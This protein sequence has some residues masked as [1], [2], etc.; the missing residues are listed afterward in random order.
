[1][2][3]K[4][5]FYLPNPPRD[6]RTFNTDSG[7]ANFRINKLENLSS[8][9]NEFVMMTI[10]SHDQYNTTI[11]SSN[12]RYRG[13]KGGRRIIFMNPEDILSS[14]ISPDSKVNITS[15]FRGVKR[16]SKSWHLVPYQIPRGNIATYFPE[17][18]ELIPLDSV[19]LG[20]N[21]PTSKSV[22]VRITKEN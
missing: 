13:I 12:D 6:S 14:N 2:R 21:T 8:S 3:I 5:G 18:N 17:A 4:E 22:L 16:T 1:M 10:R 19:A 11:Y 9:E 20:S 15:I 7:L